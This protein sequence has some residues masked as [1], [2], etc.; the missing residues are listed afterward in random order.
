MN[1]S[2]AAATPAVP[3]APAA[4]AGFALTILTL[5][6]LVNYLDRYIVAVALPDIQKE[7]GINDTQ[8]GLLGTMFV[9]GLFAVF[10]VLGVRTALRAPDRFGALLAAGVTGWVAS[11]AIV[12]MG[13]V[14]GRLPVTGVPL[15]FVSFGGSALVVTMAAAGLLVSVAR[16]SSGRSTPGRSTAGRSPQGSGAGGSRGR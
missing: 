11:Q 15:P 3:T 1:A 8:S 9:V 4:N 7:F 6:N 5:I 14:T 12:N 13:A 10:T 16:S 2:P